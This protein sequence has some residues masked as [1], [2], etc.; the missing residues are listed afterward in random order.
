MIVGGGAMGVAFCDEIIHSDPTATC[1]I[2]D[3]RRALGGHWN[4]AYPYAR[5]HQPACY[6]G[7]NSLK[8][9]KRVKNG[10]END[11]LSSKSDILEYYARLLTK[12]QDTGR[13]HFWGGYNYL[14]HNQVEIL[15]PLRTLQYLDALSTQRTW[16]SK[17][18]R[19][20]PPS[21][22]CIKASR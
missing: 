19:R 15:V 3:R 5:L 18:P 7:V 6:Y 17:Y 4:D 22:T 2:V 16:T 1:A 12:F 20:M 13:V 10:E 14:G 21:L 9:E 8:L 11:N